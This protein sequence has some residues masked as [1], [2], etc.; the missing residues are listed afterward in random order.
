ML[1]GV[2]DKRLTHKPKLAGEPGQETL[3]GLAGRHQTFL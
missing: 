1:K 3:K 2:R